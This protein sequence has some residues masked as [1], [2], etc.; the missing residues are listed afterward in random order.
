ME[1]SWFTLFLV[2]EKVQRKFFEFSGSVPISTVNPGYNYIGLR[3]NRSDAAHRARYCSTFDDVSPEHHI[4]LKVD[5]SL[6]GFMHFTTTSAG[7]AHN[8]APL[9]SKTVYN[10]NDTDWKVWHLL[11]DLPLSWEE[12]PGQ[13]YVSTEWLDIVLWD[14]SLFCDYWPL[15]CLPE[16]SQNSL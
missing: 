3:E 6:F 9:L 14:V 1:E 7:R 2:V 5:F 12:S 4:L 11:Q 10:G 13:F 15:C 16:M 8:Y